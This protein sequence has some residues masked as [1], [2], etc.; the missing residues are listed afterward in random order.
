ML[1]TAP[2]DGNLEVSMAF[3]KV[4]GY[5]VLQVLG[6]QYFFLEALASESVQ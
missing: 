3:V 2:S 6:E 5:L 1:S 4:N